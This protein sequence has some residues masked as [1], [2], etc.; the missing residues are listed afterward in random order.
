[1]SEPAISVFSAS[2]CERPIPCRRPE[3]EGFTLI[4]LLVVICVTA[5]LL[6]IA[7]PSIAQLVTSLQLS[8]ASNSFVSGLHLA[9]NE[10]IKRHGRVVLCKTADGM[11][12]T[13]TGGWEQ[14]WLIFHDANNNSQRES[15]EQI[16]HRELAL[17]ASLRMTGNLNVATYVSFVPTGAT[18]L[19]G[20]AFQAGTLTVCRESVSAADARQIVLNAAG[21]PR[22]HKTIIPSCG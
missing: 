18:K 9:R 6:T 1:M 14:G 12:C 15:S 3:Q 8:S 20:G 21:R 22:V 19:A 11:F 17:A 4:E 5:L 7:A 13:N 2:V 16:I 10:A